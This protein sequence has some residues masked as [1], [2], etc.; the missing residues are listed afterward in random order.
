MLILGSHYRN[1]L[2]VWYECPHILHR[3]HSLPTQTIDYRLYWCYY[4]GVGN[5]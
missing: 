4:R 3:M 5:W 1:I 2:D